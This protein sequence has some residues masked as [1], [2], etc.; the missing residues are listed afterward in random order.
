VLSPAPLNRPAARSL[1]MNRL[2]SKPMLFLSRLE[3]TFAMTTKLRNRRTKR[4]KERATLDT[5]T[6]LIRRPIQVETLLALRGA[7]RTQVTIDASVAR[8]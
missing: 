2:N 4:Y 5:F 3:Q 7:N 6:L 8:G 1:H